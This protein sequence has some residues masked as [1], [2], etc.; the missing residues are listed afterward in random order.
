M[1]KFELQDREYE[2]PYH[3]IPTYTKEGFAMFEEM[4]EV[5][6]EDT[7]KYLF[8]MKKRDLQYM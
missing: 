8:H 2:F 5:I 4:N 1:D 3:Y 7:V 6:K